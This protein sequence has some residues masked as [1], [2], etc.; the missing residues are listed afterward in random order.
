[1]RLLWMLTTTMDGREDDF[2]AHFSFGQF[3]RGIIVIVILRI[4]IFC[5]IIIVGL[6]TII[7][8]C[9]SSACITR[10]GCII[11]V[12]SNDSLSLERC[13]SLC[14]SRILITVVFHSIV[15]LT[16]RTTMILLVVVAI[17][18][19]V[20]IVV[21][22]CSWSSSSSVRCRSSVCRSSQSIRMFFSR[23]SRPSHF[24]RWFLL[25]RR[26]MMTMT[27]LLLGT[28]RYDDAV[29]ILIVAVIIIIIMAAA[30]PALLVV[31][32]LL[33]PSFESMI[34]WMRWNLA[35]EIRR[36]MRLLLILH[37]FACEEVE[38]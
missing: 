15:I 18:G 10:R 23:G 31:V 33:L 29:I 32:I 3:G 22:R 7:I 27:M 17:V 34:L 20:A 38:V 35:L 6:C 36:M 13:A 24:E 11:L 19:R 2:V 21:I 37:D 1:M 26:M 8:S 4:V 14:A 12:I 30:A 28:R 9:S 16:I 25:R 5:I